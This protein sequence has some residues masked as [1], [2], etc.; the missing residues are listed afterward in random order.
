MRVV[1]GQTL[2]VENH[3]VTWTVIGVVVLLGVDV[4]AHS[5][6]PYASVPR[7][8]G[9]LAALAAIAV[10][11]V[12]HTRVRR[13]RWALALL[14]VLAT[15][16]YAP[17]AGLGAAWLPVGGALAGAAAATRPGVPGRAAALL[18]L[19]GHV[20]LARALTASWPPST[21]IA[22]TTLAIAIAL[23]RTYGLDH[24]RARHRSEVVSTEITAT[25]RERRRFARDLHDLLGRQLSVVILEGELAQRALRLQPEEARRRIAALL[26]AARQTLADVRTV[27]RAYR[28][29]PLNAELTSARQV[30]EAAG[31]HCEIRMPGDEPPGDDAEPL[32]PVLFEAVTNVLRHARATTCR[33][34]VEVTPRRYRMS[35]TND[36]TV[37][38][39][40]TD[41]GDGTGLAG[42]REHVAAAGGTLHAAPE[43]P[44][45]FRLVAEIP[46]R[47]AGHDCVSARTDPESGPSVNP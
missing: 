26:D 6:G 22:V 13:R 4:V 24:L 39:V 16:T 25:R 9:A 40:S 44:G 11:L 33:I 45:S 19:A 7:L 41:G 21:A 32:G 8:L 17:L 35:V 47:P 10:T 27:V 15:L 12:L 18:V 42:A 28:R 30:L 5:T 14:A 37:E 34:V 31:I 46:R 23:A 43:P 36:G 20:A 2:R 1:S 38:P 29:P 3:H